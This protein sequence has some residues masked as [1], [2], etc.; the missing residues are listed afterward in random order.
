M[1]TPRDGS[2]LYDYSKNLI[3]EDVLKTLLELVSL[4]LL[5]F[6]HHFDTLQVNVPNYMDGKSISI[7]SNDI[8]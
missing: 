5:S 3:N 2:I 1:K 6:D 7:P 4:S 8:V